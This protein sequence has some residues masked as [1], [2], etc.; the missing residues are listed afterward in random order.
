MHPASARVGDTKFITSFF[1]VSSNPGLALI[2]AITV[3]L[4]SAMGDLLW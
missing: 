2:R 4:P 1:T 3:T